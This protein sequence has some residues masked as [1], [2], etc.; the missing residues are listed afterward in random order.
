MNAQPRVR[1]DAVIQHVQEILERSARPVRG[2]TVAGRR[3]SA[4]SLILTL[5]GGDASR[6]V[7]KRI[8]MAIGNWWR[9]LTDSPDVES[10]LWNAGITKELPHPL[11]SVYLDVSAMESLGEW[12]VV[13]AYAEGT[14]RADSRS[15]WSMI[16]GMAALHA[17]YW[18]SDAIR[19]MRLCRL[20]GVLESA[21]APLVAPSAT[22]DVPSWVPAMQSLPDFEYQAHWFD[23]LTTAQHSFY[24]KLW[25]MRRTWLPGLMSYPCTLTHGDVHSDNFLVQADGTVAVVDWSLARFSP[26]CCDAAYH[27]F[28]SLWCDAGSEAMVP[29]YAA[30]RRRRYEDALGRMLNGKPG[31]MPWD[32]AW[33][34][35]FMQM[36]SRMRPH[37][38]TTDTVERDEIILFL[39]ERTFREAMRIAE[40]L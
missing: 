21:V 18:Q 3:S 26:G 17:K 35:A 25:E 37:L 23:L 2:L 33:L 27:E 6:F 36:S 22:H 12:W 5:D 29:Q 14:G 1:D 39:Q 34:A 16:E 10:V 11:H 4:G 30:E 15:T 20:G 31:K 8:P 19:R 24:L 9:D 13:M 32:L 7:L 40:K 28:L 38:F